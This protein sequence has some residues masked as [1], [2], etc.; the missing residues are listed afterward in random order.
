MNHLV[1]YNTTNYVLTTLMFYSLHVMLNVTYRLNY[2]TLI[3]GFRIAVTNQ[4]GRSSQPFIVDIVLCSG[5]SG[6]GNCTQDIREDSR[7]T[8]KFKY[9][10]CQCEPQYEGNYG[11]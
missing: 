7:Q 5:C 6:H 8:P 1:Y 4:N 3:C 10:V 9:A 2:W 11:H